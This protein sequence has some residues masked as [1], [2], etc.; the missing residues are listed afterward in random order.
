MEVRNGR[1]ENKKVQVGAFLDGLNGRSIR[2]GEGVGMGSQSDAKP[3]YRHVREGVPLGASD[4]SRMEDHGSGSKLEAARGPL[5]DLE[6][7]DLTSSPDESPRL[8][9]GE[10]DPVALNPKTEKRKTREESTGKGILDDIMAP[11]KEVGGVEVKRIK[12]ERTGIDGVVGGF[13]VTSSGKLSDD[14]DG[15][16]NM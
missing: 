7:I 2:E 12:V 16:L 9:N 10:V 14:Q 13:L 6:I 8:E 1:R 5:Q 3:V 15:A 11:G 4:H